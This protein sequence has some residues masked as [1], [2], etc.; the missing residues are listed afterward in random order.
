MSGLRGTV[1]KMTKAIS[2]YKGAN[3]SQDLLG[4][5]IKWLDK[6]ACM[7]EIFL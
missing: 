6:C 1:K 7:G 5:L 4:F 2:K 3:M